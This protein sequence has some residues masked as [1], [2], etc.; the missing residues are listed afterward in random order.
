M[1]PIFDGP[2]FTFRALRPNL[3]RAQRLARDGVP[4][5]ARITGIRILRGEDDSP[6]HHEWALEVRRATGETFRAGCRQRLSQ[7][8]LER[9]R[10]GDEIDVLVDGDGHTLIAGEA[11]VEH[12]ELT[13]KVLKDLPADGIYDERHDLTKERRKAAP[14]RIVVA[15]ARRTTVLGMS[16]LNID[17]DVD[18][19]SEGEA[20]FRTTLKR[21]LVPFYAQHLVADGTVLP[22]CSRPG[23]TNK[24]RVDWPAAAMATPGNGLAPALERAAE[25]AT[26]P[27]SVAAATSDDW[28]AAGLAADGDL[29]ERGG[30]T[31]EQWVAVSA[32]LVRDKVKPADVDAYAVQHGVGRGSWDAAEAAWTSAM[33]GDPRIGARYGAA[34]EQ[35]RKRRR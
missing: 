8:R 10:L 13:H 9:L 4:A 33:I 30:M 35:A 21:E 17:L 25:D 16:T 28:T 11:G 32:G 6:D 27:A 3:R 26:P 5:T 18:V 12:A 24:V 29:G 19:E 1:D 31:F 2:S 7:G 20:A 34:F 14:A 22:G 15:G 23:R